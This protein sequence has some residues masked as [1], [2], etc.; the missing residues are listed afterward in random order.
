VTVRD[1][2]KERARRCARALAEFSRAGIP[3]DSPGVLV[4]QA[5][6]DELHALLEEMDRKDAA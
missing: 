6:L 4:V 2:I 1:V 5:R 3:S